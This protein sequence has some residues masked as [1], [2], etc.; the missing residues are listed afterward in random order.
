MH[1]LQTLAVSFLLGSSLCGATGTTHKA[2]KKPIAPKVFIVSMFEP[3]AEA[4][5]DIPEFDLLAHNITLPGLSPLY[6]DVHCT[7]DYEICQLITGESEINAATTV[8]SVA[9][10][11][12]FD[13]TRTY[14]FI[15]GIAGIS[16][17]MATTGSVTFARYAIQVA[18]QYEI[19]IRE[20]N[21]N[22]STGY[23]PQGADYPDQ[24]PTSIY[25]TEVFEVNAE[26]RTIAADLARKANLSD[27]AAAQAYRKYYATTNGQFKAATLGPSVLECDV[28]TSD[29][30][31]SG[32]ILGSAF[33]NTTKIWTNGTG[34]YCSTAQEDNATL[35]A[36]LRSSAR[37]LTDFSRIIVMRTAS[38][39]DRPYP[40]SSA[41]YNLL[42]ADQGGFEP[43]IENIYVAGIKVIEGIL[44]G[45]HS[46]FSAGVE[47]TNYIGDIFG[48]LGGTPD[49]GP[50]RKQALVNRGAYEKG[51]ISQH[52]S[53]RG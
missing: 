25:G 22:Y 9:F 2:S 17:K 51:S 35:E 26:L 44:D 45:W 11:P 28:A 43:A 14:F 31:Y 46:T 36:L 4:W 41:V 34:E 48:T 24:Y 5:W 47:P 32:N 42:Y 16:P 15:A 27:S 38:D 39:F 33:E 53:R 3:E 23:I 40:G 30:Y 52:L 29:V 18:L 7:E 1:L 12:L 49:F 10:S 20:L 50:G 8:T 21:S 13:L 19:D 37:K 6:P